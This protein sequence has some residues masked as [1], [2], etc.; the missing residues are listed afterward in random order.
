[1]CSS[2]GEGTMGYRALVVREVV[3]E[4]YR[5]V[6]IAAGGSVCASVAPEFIED[7]GNEIVVLSAHV[8]VGT[9][10]LLVLIARFDQLRGWERHGYKDCASWLC[11][12]T[13]IDKGAARE[14]VR[15]ARALAVLPLT[16]AAMGR[17][18][19]SFSKVRALTRKATP[20]NEGDLL[21]LA[22]GTTAAQLERMIRSW[23]PDSR[24]EDADRE[25]DVFDSRTL[26]IFPDDE[27]GYVIKGR[28]T[29]EVGAI[30][31]RALE[32]ATDALYRKAAGVSGPLGDSAGL[33]PLA[34]SA[35]AAAQRRADAIGLL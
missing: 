35:R 16:S 13:G 29:P 33:E 12:R 9:H 22:R 25:R 1:M 27:G 11:V 30:L 23:T 21:E 32:A 7:L 14:R 31:M 3:E 19:L 34:D 8:D 2:V 15:A 26:S 4:P 6:S 24:K 5:A 17:G 18:E 20:D 28:L 10:R